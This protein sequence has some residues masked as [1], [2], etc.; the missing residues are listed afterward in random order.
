MLME[1]SVTC[2]SKILILPYFTYMTGLHCFLRI[3]TLINFILVGQRGCVFF[4]EDNQ[5]HPNKSMNHQNQLNVSQ[6]QTMQK[7]ASSLPTLSVIFLLLTSIRAWKMARHGRPK[8]SGTSTSLST[9]KMIK[10]MKKLNFSTSTN[11]SSMMPL[12]YA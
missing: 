5:L 2:F 9:S 1:S 6:H 10:S 4:L 8:L 7:I 12:G 11:T 3:Y